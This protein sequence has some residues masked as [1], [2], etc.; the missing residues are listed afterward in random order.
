MGE[1]KR[2]DHAGGRWSI[3][4]R[5]VA[6]ECGH[7]VSADPGVKVPSRKTGHIASGGGGGE[8]IKV[9]QLG[10]GV[11]A[12]C[13]GK[14]EAVTPTGRKIDRRR[15]L[16]RIAKCYCAGA[17]DFRPFG[18]ETGGNRRA[19]P[20]GDIDIEI[21]AETGEGGGLR[22]QRRPA[23]PR[24]FHVDEDPA[25]VH[26]GQG[27]QAAIEDRLGQG[28]VVEFDVFE[29]EIAV[30]AVVS[31]AAE[32]GE[33]VGVGGPVELIEIAQ[34]VENVTLLAIRQIRQGKVG[35]SGAADCVGMGDLEAFVI[36]DHVIFHPRQ[37]V[38]VIGRGGL[39]VIHE[40]EEGPRRARRRIPSRTLAP[41][42]RAVVDIAI[43]TVAIRTG[44]G[45]FQD[46][47][48]QIPLRLVDVGPGALGEGEGGVGMD[49]DD[50]H[51]PVAVVAFHPAVSHVTVIAAV[52]LDPVGEGVAGPLQGGHD[53]VVTR[54][55][56]VFRQE[57]GDRRDLPVLQAGVDK[58]RL[59][60]FHGGQDD[61]IEHRHRL[62]A[63]GVD[64]VPVGFRTTG[65]GPVRV[66][67]HQQAHPA[68]V[69]QAAIGG[70]QRAA[71]E[72][73]GGV[74]MDLSTGGFEKGVE[75]RATQRKRRPEI[76]RRG[77]RG[78]EVHQTHPGPQNPQRQAATTAFRTVD[79]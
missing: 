43:L 34:V 72:P 12:G 9:I 79:G 58:A 25:L 28:G 2:G 45:L 52:L 51:R 59:A 19:L 76:A 65:I 61:A 63:H 18:R 71:A 29:V 27:R 3:R 78:S 42:R 8:H 13:S 48:G 53:R 15:R 62:V 14:L 37:G 1:I 7:G 60:A 41:G 74:G 54:A 11:A 46:V 22:L 75:L 47:P 39:A 56:H 35:E 67:K 49:V 31:P 24:A 70:P 73:R 17:G 57:H 4:E 33:D 40:S 69:G 20:V 10:H 5:G 16:R 36:A 44:G 21:V 66:G 50:V 6:G 26:P 23:G 68:E 55:V 64:R 30:A 32:V 38:G 77:K